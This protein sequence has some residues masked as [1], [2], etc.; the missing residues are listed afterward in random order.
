M[1]FGVA[2]ARYLA[3]FGN[4]FD[5]VH[6][7]ALSPGAA[8]AVVALSRRG[9]YL[10][11][12]DW[13]EVWG[14]SGWRSYVGRSPGE[15]AARLEKSLARSTH[16]P[17]VYSQLHSRRLVELRGRADALLLT[18]ILP[19]VEFPIE[20][21]PAAPYILLVNRL[22][23]EKQTSAILPALLVARQEVP[24]LRAIIV[25]SGPQQIQLQAQIADLELTESV[26]L[27]DNVSDDELAALMQHAL[28]IALFS[29]RE[30]YGLVV[31]EAT[32][33]GTPSI[34]LAHPDSAASERIS[35]GENGVLVRTLEP[36]E[37]ASAILA[38]HAAGKLLREQTLSW[39]KRHDGELRID[40]SLQ[41]LISRYEQDA[42]ERRQ[43][44]WRSARP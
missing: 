31:T 15:V 10:P 30:G 33:F 27:R 40:H 3:R 1:T 16:L 28:C 22:I 36:P 19:P 7:T 9:G 23:P 37:V 35:S 6:S 24:E 12:L 29:R 43:A 34:V 41:T 21:T 25:G 42:A 17:V 20:S 39:R 2:V 44:G 11:V 26:S 8:Q 4:A 5:V 38:L 18:G 13:W 32:T 14:K